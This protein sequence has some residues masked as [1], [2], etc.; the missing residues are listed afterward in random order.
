M[1]PWIVAVLGLITVVVFLAPIIN[2]R[3]ELALVELV[4]EVEEH[5]ALE[6]PDDDA[7]EILT[8]GDLHDYLWGKLQRRNSASCLTSHCFYLLRERLM[9]EFGLRKEEIRPSTRLDSMV[10]PERRPA[11]NNS[12]S[13]DRAD[14]DFQTVGDL[15]REKLA[16]SGNAF[17]RK[18][19][20]AECW[21]A[22]RKLA[23]EKLEVDVERVR[24]D[25]RFWDLLP[26]L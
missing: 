22:I 25:A 21:Q 11:T 13:M 26:R 5:F 7:E 16:S 8:A 19:D 18:W 10:A 20:E 3:D 14:R 17:R 1:L 9:R 2:P 15:A 24:Y 12:L 4:M 23:S 6:I